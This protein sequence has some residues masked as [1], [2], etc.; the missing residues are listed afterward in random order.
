V[1]HK[2]T[3]RAAVRC[4][5][6]ALVLA[7]LA[8]GQSVNWRRVGTSAVELMLAAPATGPV[9]TVWFGPDGRLFART[10]SERTFETTDFEIWTPSAAAVTPPAALHP[11]V[12]RRP[13]SGADVVAVGFG[14]IYALG[15]NL[16]RTEDAGLTWNNLT[17]YKTESVIGGGQRS[18][19]AGPNGQLVVANDHGVWRSM[20]GGLSWSGLNQGLPNLPVRRILSTAQG[21]AGTRIAVEGVGAMELPPGTRVW[22]PSQD[23]TLAREAQAKTGISQSIG[24]EVRALAAGNAYTYAGTAD[25]RIWVWL[26]VTGAARQTDTGRVT[27]A[28]ERIGVDPQHP[29]IALAAVGTQVLHTMNGGLFWD[30]LDAPNN[31]VVR[32]VTADSA[33]GAIYIATDQGVFWARKQLDTASTG[34]PTWTSLNTGLQQ[35]PATD[36]LLDPA[37]VRLY[38]AIDGYGVYS[39]VAPH[40]TRN[41]RVVNAADFSTRAAAPGG[42]LSVVGGRVNSATAGDLNFP[43]L[44]AAD[45]GSQIQVPFEAAGPTVTL[46]LATASGPVQIGMRVQ[47]VSPA[48][49]VTH[50]G[51]PMLQDAESGLL[52]DSRNAA[53]SGSRLLVFATGLGRVNPDWPTGMQAPL[54]GPPSVVAS[55]H[56][57]LNGTEIPV[58]RATLAPGYVGF[59]VVEV[60]IPTLNNAG[61][62]ELY[63]TAGGVESNRVP[64]VIEQ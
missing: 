59:Y 5:S 41:L 43:V 30:H 54:E 44:A 17:G 56:A 63:I 61:V 39:A 51:V 60:Q 21:T 4:T 23:D 52:L 64:I 42:L 38:A 1:C 53:K 25:G 6:L 37:G 7:S 58:S 46:A 62:N 10:H 11:Q 14:Q 34:Q 31:A 47:P 33:A 12:A 55:I 40:R 9:D 16:F 19:A 35:A 32:G 2:E 3:V 48:I 22:L 18:V 49:F 28:V 20:D 13:E 15:R 36:V 26:Q 8:A 45:D 27:G 57:Y 29:Q 50:E 24:A